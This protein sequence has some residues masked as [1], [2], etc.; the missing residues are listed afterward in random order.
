M[1]WFGDTADGILVAPPP[2]DDHDRL[3]A[4]AVDRLRSR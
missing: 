4:T 2:S 3:L 1:E